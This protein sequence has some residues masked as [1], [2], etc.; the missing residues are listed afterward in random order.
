MKS[1]FNINQFPNF[2]SSTG[3]DVL[4]EAAIERQYQSCSENELDILASHVSRPSGFVDILLSGEIKTSR[5]VSRLLGSVNT[6]RHGDRIS[7]YGENKTISFS[8]GMISWRYGNRDLMS[9]RDYC[10]WGFVTS[11]EK[12]L[13]SAIEFS[14]AS[15]VGDV[16]DF[17]L[18]KDN[19]NSS[20]H[21][22][23]R[24]GELDDQDGYGNIFEII[25]HG[26]AADSKILPNYKLSDGV[27]LIPE[28]DRSQVMTKLIKRREEYQKLL[29]Q[30]SAASGDTFVS[31]EDRWI[32][33]VKITKSYLQNIVD[34]PIDLDRLPIL[35]YP[36]SHLQVAMRHLSLK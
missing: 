20:F 4:D 27:V 6:H 11:A 1:T 33:D 36:H 26:P 25:L 10:G 31:I 9:A 7:I 29:E 21:L 24:R 35:Y 19:F 8:A 5:E 32:Y 17:D 2:N 18:N 22:A 28:A 13:Q 14:H 34:R 12:F 30:L 3:V 16:I 23:R 15:S